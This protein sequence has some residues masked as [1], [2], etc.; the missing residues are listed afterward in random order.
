MTE[1]YGCAPADILAAIGPCISLCC[2]ET[3]RDVPD[4]LRAGM[5]Q[6]A[7]T[8][9]H[10]LAG[11]EKYMVDLKGANRRWLE[12][13]GVRPEHI[14]VCPACTA[15]DLESFWSHRKMGNRR[16]SMAGVI[17]IL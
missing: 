6:E 9:I 1:E 17:Q 16:G 14:A 3:H 13:A 2:F 5:G 10:P 15:C 8:V 7:E 4:G 11:S 12:R